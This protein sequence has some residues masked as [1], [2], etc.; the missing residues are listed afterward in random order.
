MLPPLSLSIAVLL[1][2]PAS[3]QSQQW[4]AATVLDD[5]NI[6]EAVELWA[7]NFRDQAVAR[8]LFGG[9]L[10]DWDTSRV[11]SMA[12][13]FAGLEDTADDTED[14]LFVCNP[15]VGNWNTA[16]VTDMSGMFRGCASFDQNLRNWNT[17]AVTDMSFLFHVSYTGIYIYIYKCCVE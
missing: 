3:A 16:R 17:S 14:D 8:E 13:L 4:F 6:H 10:E 11:T 5:T 9:P 2:L 12:G 15:P 1:L 7:G